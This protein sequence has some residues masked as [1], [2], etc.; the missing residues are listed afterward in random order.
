MSR[1]SLRQEPAD[2]HE[3]APCQPQL[4][5]LEDLYRLMFLIRVFEERLLGELGTGSVHGTTHTYIGQEANAVGIIPLLGRDDLVFSNHRC[6]GHF[7]ALTCD[8]NGLASELLGRA[9]GV[10]GGRGG[11]QHLHARNFYSYGILGGN[12]PCAVGAAL[13][14]K[15]RNSAM[16]AVFIG[17]GTLGEGVVYES[18]NIAS[19]WKLPVLFVVENNRI[20]QS[21]PIEQALA[22]SLAKRFDAFGI[23]C[24][25]LESS[26]VLEI[27]AESQPIIAMVRETKRPAALVINTYRLAAHSKSD[28]SREQSVIS[29]CWRHDPLSIH[30]ERIPSERREQ[31]ESGCRQQVN[32]A[33]SRALEA[34][35]PEAGEL[36]DAL[37]PSK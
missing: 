9:T 8:V 13:A 4:L 30:R 34:P 17:D 29:E 26:D 15:I 25:D 35:L 12:V 20:A 24:I 3:Q 27:R 2:G 7:I 5:D 23:P 31:I 16:A 22:G 6:H 11:S 32:E 14:G 37:E 21:T 10:C 1:T 19:L 33:F 28:D 18:L 36:G